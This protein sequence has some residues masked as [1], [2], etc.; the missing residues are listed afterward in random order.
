VTFPYPRQTLPLRDGELAYFD[1][2]EGPPLLF[3]HGLVGDYTH[4]EHVARRLVAAG[5]RVIG[6]DL[7]GC[8]SSH[9]R[10]RTHDLAG[11]AR[12]VVEV[13][14]ALELDR[15]TLVGHS[16]GGAIVARAALRLR[17]RVDGLVLLSSAGLRGYP[18]ATELAARAFLR[19]AILVRSLE[20]L[21]QPLLKLVLVRDNEYTRQF[22]V[23]ALS[24]PVHPTLGEMA[25]V[26]ED[27]VPDLL[28][29]T[30]VEVA[31]QLDVPILVVWGDSDRLVAPRVARELADRQRRIE[32]TMLP[33]CGHMPMLELPDDVSRRVLAFLSERID[34]RRRGASPRYASEGPGAVALG[35]S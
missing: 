15:V 7:P 3:V 25:R 33:Q 19:R 22:V 5:R 29:P 4:F 20:R 2:G 21:A 6:I 32:L 27:L 11:Y 14:D 26:M 9:K 10:R 16:A 13:V 1:V 34:T 31:P 17:D 8:G 35:V 24:R 23:D 28:V 12:D 30:V 18:R